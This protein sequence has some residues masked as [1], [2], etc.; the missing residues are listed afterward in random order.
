VCELLLRYG[1]EINARNSVLSTPLVLASS[2]GFVDTVAELYRMGGDL[3][4]VNTQQNH[5]LQMASFHG[6]LDMVQ[7][8]LSAPRLGTATA[9][10]L[11]HRNI[12]G[13][14][15]LSLAVRDSHHSRES[16]Y[17]HCQ[18]QCR[19]ALAPESHS[20]PTEALSLVALGCP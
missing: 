8:F 4:A 16:S 13:N 1:A 9:V 10:Y 18:S 20:R 3:T 12:D 5:G 17:H 6:H 19:S 15:S 7:W 11:N 2:R 14:T